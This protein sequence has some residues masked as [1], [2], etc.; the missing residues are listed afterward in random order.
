MNIRIVF[1][2]GYS[3]IFLAVIIQTAFH[4]A[5]DPT[6]LEKRRLAPFPTMTHISGVLSQRFMKSFNDYIADNFGFRKLFIRA[7]NFVDVRLLRTPSN[8]NVIIG[9][10]DFLF[11]LADWRSFVH[12]HSTATEAQIAGAAVQ[13][14]DFQNR[15]KKNGIDFL[16]VLSPNK[17]TIYPEYMPRPRYLLHKQS[18]RQRWDAAL[19][20]VGVNYL[21]P[22]SLLIAAKQTTRMYYKG[23]HHWTKFGGL[24]V[25]RKIVSDLA[26]MLRVASPELEVIGQRPDGWEDTGGGS[27]DELLGV[28]AARSNV[29]PI[30]RASGA[31][32]PPGIVIG[33]SFI[34]WLYLRDASSSLK[35]IEKQRPV[36]QFDK[37]I[38]QL[39]GIRYVV[40]A[41][42][43]AD[44]LA[45][46]DATF[47]R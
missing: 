27:L 42:W 26:E 44:T 14:R 5:P 34:R 13:I 36:E 35:Q 28:K 6:L 46:T 17:G 10:D 22:T 41:Y 1:I 47:W 11:D 18:E 38:G 45:F 30:I 4:L 15:L 31:K 29:E 37:A 19:A 32:L 9:K 16:F 20:R 2:A 3:A 33:D 40:V 12:W 39:R 24:L 23:D 25:T 8:S 21:D 7:N 43:E